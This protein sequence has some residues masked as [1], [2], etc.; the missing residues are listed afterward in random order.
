MCTLKMFT[1]EQLR[2]YTGFKENENTFQ[3]RV[4]EMEQEFMLYKMY[5]D[6][7]KT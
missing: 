4:Q 1:S 2:E 3:N 5:A 7:K 6:K